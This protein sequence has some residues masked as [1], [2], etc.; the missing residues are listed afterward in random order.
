MRNSAIAN[1]EVE[2]MWNSRIQAVK[3]PEA[4]RP[5]PW[6]AGTEG[7]AFGK[8]RDLE[9]GVELKMETHIGFLVLKI[10]TPC[11]SQAVRLQHSSALF[12][13]VFC[14]FLITFAVDLV[15]IPPE[16]KYNPRYFTV[17]S[18]R[19]RVGWGMCST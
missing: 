17:F 2:I 1:G 9:T 12:S 16:R 10:R 4:R 7:K 6:D 3:P 5:S 14:C 19:C 13:L 18:S 15:F 11:P 8:G